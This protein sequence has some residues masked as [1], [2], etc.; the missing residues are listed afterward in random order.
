MLAGGVARATQ[1]CLPIGG[2]GRGRVS[3]S[4]KGPK[5]DL[6][7]RMLRL[8]RRLAHIAEFIVTCSTW[9]WRFLFP[10]VGLKPMAC[11]K[12]TGLKPSLTHFLLFMAGRAQALF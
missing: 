10:T 9:A 12:G 7:A 8:V 6:V 11:V 5:S 4:D 2:L 3:G 1:L